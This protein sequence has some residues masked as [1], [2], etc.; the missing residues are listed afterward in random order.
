MSGTIVK[1]LVKEGE[2]VAAHQP[3]VVLEAMKME[4]TIVAPSDGIVT[5]VSY[6]VGALVDGGASL[7]E[8][9]ADPQRTSQ[10]T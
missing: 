7:I 8:L 10:R 4:H 5:G 2:T 1:I 3:L 9:D 6:G